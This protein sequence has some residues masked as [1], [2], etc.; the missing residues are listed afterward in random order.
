MDLEQ[1]LSFIRK[2]TGLKNLKLI[3]DKAFCSKAPDF[4]IALRRHLSVK[5]DND[6]KVLVLDALPQLKSLDV[7][8]SH[9]PLT[10]GYLL[11]E[12]PWSVGLDLEASSRVELKHVQRLSQTSE[13]DFLMDPAT[14]WTAKEAAFKAFSKVDGLELTSDVVIMSGK[15]SQHSMTEFEAAP[16]ASPKRR[17]RGWIFA[18]DELMVALFFF[19]T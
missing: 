3:L 9:C 10:G 15:M 12:K 14:L 11:A 4:R 2:E 6:P 8:I 17:G 13:Q 16:K 5:T 1:K 18:D 19:R 7:S